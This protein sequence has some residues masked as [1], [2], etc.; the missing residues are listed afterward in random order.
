LKWENIIMDD[1]DIYSLDLYSKKNRNGTLKKRPSPPLEQAVYFLNEL[2]EESNSPYVFP[3]KIDLNNYISSGS[4]SKW[5]A[6]LT[7]KVFGKSVTNYL[8]RHT[9][10]ERFHVLVAEGK[11]SVENACLMLGQ[12][13]KTWRKHYSHTDEKKQRKLLNK[14]VL[15]VDY[16]APEKKA[17]LEEQVDLLGKIILKTSFKS[18]DDFSKEE[19]KEVEKDLMKLIQASKKD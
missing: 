10:A 2:K 15:D 11:M 4:V 5:F 19:I 6:R 14:Q 18:K 13:E 16:I 1:P 8:L 7:K 17:K 12:T 9:T 3:S